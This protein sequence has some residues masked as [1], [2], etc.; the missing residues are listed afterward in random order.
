MPPPFKDD[1]Q[2][3]V[4]LAQTR[5]AMFITQ[6]SNHAPMGVPVWFEWTG[7]QVRM[8]AGK[9]SGKIRRIETDPRVSVVVTNRVGE[10]EAWVAFDGKVRISSEGGIE[11]ASKLAEKYWDLSDPPAREKLNGWQQVPEAFCMLTLSPDR[12]RTGQ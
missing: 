5:L 8:F 2:R 7:S 6:R 3:D 1:A 10:P 11:L 4:F 9:D 12:I